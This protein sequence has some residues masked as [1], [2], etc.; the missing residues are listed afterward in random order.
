MQEMKY[1]NEGNDCDICK[2]QLMT[3]RDGTVEDCRRRQNGLSCRFEERDIRTCPV[4]EHE[5]DR[6]D[7]YFTKD[8][9]GMT[10]IPYDYE[11]AYNKS[12]EDMHEFFVE[13]MFKQGKKVVYALKEIRA[14]DQFEVE[15][16]PQFKKMDEVPPEGRSIKKDNDK[17]QRNLN[18]KNARKYVERLIN[19]NFTDRD[20]WLTFTYDN[21]HLPPDGDIDAAIKNVQKFIRRVNYQRK[22]MGLPNARYVYVTAYNPTEE[23]R[24]HHHIVMDGDM[25]MDV[26]DYELNHENHALKLN[27]GASDITK[28][29]YGGNAMSEIPLIWVKRWTQN[30]YHFVVFCEEQYDDTYKAYAHTDADGNVLPVTYFPMY[31][32]SVVNN[33][34][35]SLSGLTPTASMADEQETTAA[36]QNGDRWDKQSFSEINLMYEMCTMI[37]CSTNSQGKFGNGNSQ[38]DN[39]LQTGTLNG[40]GQFFGYTST[41][42]AVKV[43]YCE[44]FFANYWKRLRG[45][46]LINGVYHVKAVPPYNSTGAGYTNTGLT[47]SGTSGG[48]CSRMEMASDIGRIPTVA[49]GS[50]TTYECDGLWFNNTIVAVALFGGSRG[51]GSKCGL[52]FWNVHNPATSVYT[53]VVASLSCKPPV[54][55][56]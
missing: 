3:G 14:G 1:F 46:L 37:T 42:Q 32:G 49:S 34:M 50:E 54:A 19:E 24:W 51:Y 27:G 21:E 15:I 36:K 55:A 9:H 40:K 33:R 20:L 17:A 12:L 22:K 44:N 47:P 7:M 28:T 6:E 29:S 43:F 13:Q 4:C 8:C 23:I 39:F 45:L 30:N 56:A 41:T 52:S 48:Y 10:F 31:E 38:S 16:Y 2:N 53:Y 35:R 18:D 5:V 25:D 11:A 26:V